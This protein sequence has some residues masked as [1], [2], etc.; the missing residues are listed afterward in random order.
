MVNAALSMAR[1]PPWQIGGH[2][3]R[4]SNLSSPASCPPRT[5]VDSAPKPG[6][7]EWCVKE[8]GA[9]MRVDSLR[10]LNFRSFIDSG[11]I[12]LGAMNVLVGAN[13]AGKS[14]VLRG[15]YLMQE[16]AGGAWGDVRVGDSQATIEM[17]IRDVQAHPHFSAYDISNGRLLIMISTNTDRRSGTLQMHLGSPDTGS[18]RQVPSV[19]GIDPSH[20]V[21]PYLSKRKTAGYSED[22][23]HQSA[24][25]V[26]SNMSNLA[27]KLSRIGAAP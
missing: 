14:S 18:G 21:V 7:W 23:R 24:M 15:L 5:S 19:P 4:S 16:G 6:H 10:L 2:T 1:W 26:S 3:R 12:H 17:F 22:V 25:Q 8:L 20:F 27:A 11:P 9:T 13:N